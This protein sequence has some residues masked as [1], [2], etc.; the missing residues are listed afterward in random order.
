MGTLAIG[1]ANYGKVVGFHGWPSSD[2]NVGE[3]ELLY[4]C[5]QV[6]LSLLRMVNNNRRSGK[7]VM[8][9]KMR[10]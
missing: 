9:I 2:A 8:L 10:Y 7:G 3:H 5:H 1:C 4:Q 6:F